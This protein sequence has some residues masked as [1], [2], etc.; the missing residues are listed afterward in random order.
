MHSSAEFISYQSTA[1]FSRIVTDYIAADEKLKDFYRHPVSIEG[2]KAAMA[3]RKSDKAGRQLLV[4]QLRQQY[5][6]TPL[7]Q[8]QQYHLQLL[9]ADTTFTITTAHQPNI[10]TGHLYFIYKILHAIKLADQL[11]EAIPG[12]HFVP[13]YYM[14][15]EDADL[16]ELGQVYIHGRNHVWQTQQSGAVGRMKVDKALLQMIGT[17]A[18]EITVLP[19]GEA[20]MQLV[21]D[22][23]REGLTI[24]QATFALVN[25][26]FAEYGL[27]ILLPDNQELKRA[28]IPVVE[29]ELNEQ[30]SSK[31]VAGTVSRFPQEYKVQAAGREV[32]LFYLADG[33]RE[34]IEQEGNNWVVVN[35]N[36]RFTDAELK[37]ELHN[38]PERFSANV[39]LRPVFQ[40]MILPNVAFIGGG[41]E[42]AYWLEL[43]EVFEAAGV[44]FPVLVVRNS[45]MIAANKPAEL[46]S[47]LGFSLTD[48]FRSEQDLLNELVKRNSSLQLSLEKER[49]QLADLYNKMKTISG[50]IDANLSQHTEALHVQADKKLQALEKKMLRAERRKYRDQQ[51]QLHAVKSSLFPGNGLQERVDNLL[52]YYGKWGRG[53][54][55]VVYNNSLG[56]EQ[57]F[58]IIKEKI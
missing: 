20:I 56:L 16:D 29:K 2:I 51:G 3:G 18:G 35:T 45:F 23:Y 7:N 54:L 58:C 11:N 46:A 9:K 48:L 52:P 14:G 49:E 33:L 21:R 19:H 1:H 34:R 55:E 38:H 57:Q 39:I 10:F 24:E 36:L 47:K 43:Q 28:F 37:A 22:C 25:A 13:V 50:N 8:K 27:L 26:L 40:E 32:N 12:N 17:I 30:F 31:A 41:G 15:S 44:P 4:E 42:I 5:E 6:G 53:F